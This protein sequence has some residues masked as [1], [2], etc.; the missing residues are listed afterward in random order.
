MV[1]EEAVDSARGPVAA[2]PGVDDENFA[3][4]AS[5]EDRG[6]EA[7]G[8]AADDDAVVNHVKAGR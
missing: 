5:E 1:S 2:L 6:G 3:A 7:G 8:A 4:V